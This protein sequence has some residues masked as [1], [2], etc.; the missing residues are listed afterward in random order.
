MTGHSITWNPAD[1]NPVSYQILLNGSELFS[2]LWNSTGETMTVSLDGLAIGVYNYT[3]VVT[4]IGGYTT[5]DTVIVTVV[6]D[7][8]IPTI[9]SPDN[10]TIYEGS[11]MNSIVWSPSDDYPVSYQILRDGSE[12]VT[13]DWDGGNISI[14]IDGLGLGN[15]NYTI[16]VFDIGG[17]SVTDTVWI[18]VLDGTA[19]TI[20]SPADI[21]YEVGET[22]N[23]IT[24]TPTDL[25][26][27]SYTI[28]R[29]STVIESDDWDGGT[30]TINVDGLSAGSYNYTLVVTDVG[31]NTATDTVIVTVTTPTT[32][33]TTT[34]TPP[35]NTTTT[36]TT[37]PD[38]VVLVIAIAGAGGA[39]IVVIII[40][41]YKKGK[42]PKRGGS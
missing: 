24:W 5:I 3:I 41:L 1:A 19:P 21:E 37:P 6:D 31:G 35:T 15:Y 11:T 23:S 42:L 38:L 17:N 33:P 29:D 26:P 36:T 10:Q 27:A 13:D 40:F 18:T 14:S 9:D 30:I 34:T 25:H 7:L 2:D 8:T 20:D 22:G 39:I 32:T 16:V 28:Y 4:D 12:L